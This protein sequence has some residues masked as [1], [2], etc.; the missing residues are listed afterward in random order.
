MLSFRYFAYSVDYGENLGTLALEGTLR[1]QHVYFDVYYLA[2]ESLSST[3]VELHLCGTALSLAQ[4]PPEGNYTVAS[5]CQSLL[6]LN[7]I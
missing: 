1:S 2:T 4:C 7:E 5:I 6:T 3:F